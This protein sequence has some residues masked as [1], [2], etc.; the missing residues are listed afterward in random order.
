MAPC[1]RAMR[2][3]PTPGTG[4]TADFFPCVRPRPVPP[5]PVT[6]CADVPIT[7]SST[8]ISRLYFLEHLGVSQC[9]ISY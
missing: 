1:A 6:L 4:I 5:S 2:S 9:Y 7:R 8:G 3:A